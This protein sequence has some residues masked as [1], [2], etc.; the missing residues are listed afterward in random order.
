[1]KK[2]A[3]IIIEELSGENKERIMFYIDKELHA[4]FKRVCTDKNV[5]MSNVIERLIENFLDELKSEK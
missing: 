3:K 4:K 2:A 5:R 1:M